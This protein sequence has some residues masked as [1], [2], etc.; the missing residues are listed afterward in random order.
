MDQ[1]QNEVVKWLEGK[2]TYAVAITVLACGVLDAYGVVVPEFVWAA[3]AAFGLG[4]LRSGVKANSGA[5]PKPP[6]EE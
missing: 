5:E 3:L 6:S 1:G 2:K 4:F